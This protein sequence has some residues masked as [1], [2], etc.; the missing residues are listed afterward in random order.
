MKQLLDRDSL[1]VS[2][3]R[4]AQQHSWHLWAEPSIR[5][6]VGPKDTPPV[7]TPEALTNKGSCSAV[8]VCSQGLGQIWK[9][10]GPTAGSRGSTW[11]SLT[12]ATPHC[13]QET[14]HRM[15]SPLRAVVAKGTGSIDGEDRVSPGSGA[16]SSTFTVVLAEQVLGC[17]KT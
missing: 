14:G 9:K 8:H 11:Q 1:K 17:R 7:G 12:W 15:Q 10:E 16:G 5:Q 3:P 6:F 2:L 13:P 4:V